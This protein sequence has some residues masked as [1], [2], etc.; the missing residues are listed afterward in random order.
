MPATDLVLRSGYADVLSFSSSY[1]PT[2]QTTQI[3]HIFI[4][5]DFEI[6]NTDVQSL[7]QFQYIHLTTL[8]Q[9]SGACVI[10]FTGL[11]MGIAIV[12]D[13]PATLVMSV[14]VI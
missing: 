7:P 8:N 5:Y 1:L 4:G 13:L 11:T 6:K 10:G 9:L 14:S 12:D 3:R 2:P